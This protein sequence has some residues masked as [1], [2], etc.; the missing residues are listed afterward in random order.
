MNRKKR[1]GWESFPSFLLVCALWAGLLSVL[2]SME[3][4]A[5]ANIAVVDNT[6]LFREKDTIFVSFQGGNIETKT[7]SPQWQMMETDVPESVKRS[8]NLRSDRE[9]IVQYN[10][11]GYGYTGPGDTTI[12]IT[13]PCIGTIQNGD[14]TRESIGVRMTVSDIYCET[15]DIADSAAQVYWTGSNYICNIQFY[16]NF[17]DGFYST[18]I[19]YLTAIYEFFNTDSGAMISA[20]GMNMTFNSL[21][22]VS[23]LYQE[24]VEYLPA[25]SSADYK[26]YVTTDTNIIQ[27]GNRF[28]GGNN[29]FED[30]IGATSF[31][32]NSVSFE[33]ID[34]T[35]KIAYTAANGVSYW[36]TLVAAPIAANVPEDPFKAGIKGNT[37]V[38]D[39]GEVS[40]GQTLVYAVCQRVQN[41]GINGN[42]HYQSMYF[43]D[44]LPDE[45]TYQSAAIVKY[46][47]NDDGTID[48][49]NRTELDN[50]LY[51][52]SRH[53]K[54]VSASMTDTWLSDNASYDGQVY[55]LEVTVTVNE[56]AFDRFSNTGKVG[57]N[58]DVADTTPIPATPAQPDLSITK[59]VPKYEW[60]VGETVNYEVAVTQTKEGACARNVVIS[61]VSIPEELILEEVEITGVK[62]AKITKEKNTWTAT[63]PRMD[64]KDTAKVIFSCTVT[65]AAN[66]KIFEN[67]AKV[68]ADNAD[69]KQDDAE[70]FINS[71]KLTVTKEVSK[72][73]W[74]VGD[75]VEYIVKVGN[76]EA[77][78]IARSRR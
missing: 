46:G 13:Y 48:Y 77:G 67:T 39:F 41:L 68:K 47:I 24:G 19:S 76:I 65:E 42:A 43:E 40:I 51:T 27:D 44:T 59:A 32:R 64:Y 78:T 72:Y 37:A 71:P 7:T 21:N 2:L 5:A 23:T 18:N 28:V 49:G 58:G 6:K 33:S 54:V 36:H 66:G 69:E 73:E 29:N 16:D 31:L 70:I 4:K 1:L 15:V 25:D 74:Y 56:D 10:A 63:V 11:G 60:A 45:V 62:N 34:H 14:G 9:V 35:P 75:T 17:W 52:L 57:V 61:D 55:A 38:S 26:A 22:C 12:T 50:S 8:L 3:G 20:Q 53:G 30:Q